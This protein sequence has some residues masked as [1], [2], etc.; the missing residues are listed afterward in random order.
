MNIKSVKKVEVWI[1]ET[2]EFDFPEYV[3]FGD[4]SWYQ[5]MGDTLEPLDYWDGSMEYKFLDAI[6][7]GKDKPCE[8]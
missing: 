8:P 5:R 1:V 2:D 7:K 4:G 3:R 6:D